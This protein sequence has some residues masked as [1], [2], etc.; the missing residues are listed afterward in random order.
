MMSVAAAA[1]EW[2]PPWRRPAPGQPP[3]L[4]SGVTDAPVWAPGR[5]GREAPIETVDAVA[6]RRASGSAV[7]V[8]VARALAAV[9][10]MAV[11]ALLSRQLGTARFG[12]LSLIMVV[13]VVASTL[14]DLGTTPLA[15][16]TMAADPAR[17]REVAA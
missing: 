16:S 14:T 7:L 9:L 6:A 12:D 3:A 2:P 8:V 4:E 5:R 10:G 13:A 1:V 17:R 15:V 11:A